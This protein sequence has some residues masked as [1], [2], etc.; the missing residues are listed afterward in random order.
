LMPETLRTRHPQ[1]RAAY[2]AD[3][4]VRAMGSG[5]ELR[6]RRKDGSEFPV[7]I[8]L[9]PLQTESGIIVSSAIRDVT[10]Q[11]A[12][13]QALQEAKQRAEAAA[14][15]KSEFLANMSHEL[16]TPLTAIMGISDLLLDGPHTSA[17]RRRFIELQRNAGRGLLTLINDILDFSRIEAGH[18][19]IES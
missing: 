7:A 12:A 9:G 3:R 5:L 19:A 16:R 13:E 8:S 2:S 14:N 15:A 10:A 6:G 18:L 4:R 11:K 17:E 1:H